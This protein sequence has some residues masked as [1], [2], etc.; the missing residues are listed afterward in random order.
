M[1][2][3]GGEWIAPTLIK[4]LLCTSISLKVVSGQHMT[5]QF[6]LEYGAKVNNVDVNGKNVLHLA[7][8]CGHYSCLQLILSNMSKKDAQVMDNQQCTALHWACY[9]G[10]N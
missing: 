6:L 3:S 10:T 4:C 9:N 5:V 8:A 7:A 2:I 1:L